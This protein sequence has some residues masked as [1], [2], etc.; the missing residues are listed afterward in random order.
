MRQPKIKSQHSKWIAPPLVDRAAGGKQAHRGFTLIEL[1]TVIAII[2]ILAAILIPVTAQV[3]ESTRRASCQNNIRQQLLAM[4]LFAEDRAGIVKDDAPPGATPQNTGFW[5]VLTA[6]NDNAPLDL[7]PEYTDDYNIF[8]CP[9][10]KNII[11][12][13][14]MNRQ[15]QLNDLFINAKNAADSSGGHSYEYLGIYGTKEMQGIVKTP[16]TVSGLETFTVLVFDGD[17]DGLENCP[18]ETNN[19]GRDGWNW[20]FADGHVEW[21]SRER[22]N[23][24]S[25]RSFHSATRCP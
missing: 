20:G 7:Y 24:V 14:E 12:P 10:T 4:F 2:G 21:V 6:S 16:V 19:H 9:S 5:Y 17:D 23:E 3:R 11:R 22:S 25:D 13:D 18:D 15:G 8:L 1:L